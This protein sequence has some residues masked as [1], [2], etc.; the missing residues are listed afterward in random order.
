MAG[1]EIG[2]E[3]THRAA[4]FYRQRLPVQAVDHQR[5]VNDRSQWNA[6][7]KIIRRRV[8]TQVLSRP[9][10]LHHLQNARELD[11][12]PLPSRHDPAHIGHLEF[13]GNSRQILERQRARLSDFPTNGQHKNLLRGIL[14]KNELHWPIAFAFAGVVP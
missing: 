2:N 7:M 14:T 3:K 10:R 13:S 6:R 8:Q 11:R 9:F 5:P 12:I 1:G 4:R